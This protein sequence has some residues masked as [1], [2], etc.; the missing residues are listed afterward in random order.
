MQ[1]RERL[2]PLRLYYALQLCTKTRRDD[3][4]E[5]PLDMPQDIVKNIASQTPFPADV[6]MPLN[7]RQ[8]RFGT[9]Y[10]CRLSQPSPGS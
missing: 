4:F 9:R 10:R 6:R 2:T 3:R 8:T 7:Q 1:V 5:F